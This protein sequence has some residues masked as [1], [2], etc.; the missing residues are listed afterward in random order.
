MS[1]HHNIH[2]FTWTS[3]DGKTHNQIDHILVG[4]VIL[5]HL[6]SDHS[7]QQTVMLTT[8]WW[9]QKLVIRMIRSSRMIW[10]GQ[11]E[12]DIGGK[13]KRKETIRKTKM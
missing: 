9:W 8:I 10:A 3:P 4:D 7:R 11:W 13:A 6:L 12:E 5:V 2:K 1:P